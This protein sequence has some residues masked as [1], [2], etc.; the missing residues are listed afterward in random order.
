MATTLKRTREKLYVGIPEVYKMVKKRRKL[1][2][3]IEKA[4]EVAYIPPRTYRVVAK[5]CFKVLTTTPLTN[6]EV[7]TSL[8]DVEENR[9]P[10][11]VN[12][13]IVRVRCNVQ[14]HRS[15]DEDEFT[16]DDYSTNA[17]EI[18]TRMPID[19]NT[20]MEISL[21]FHAL[22]DKDDLWRPHLK[23]EDHRGGYKVEMDDEYDQVV[24]VKQTIMAYIPFSC[25]GEENWHTLI[26]SIEDDLCTYIANEAMYD[27][28]VA[29]SGGAID[30]EDWLKEEVF[31]EIPDGE[32]KHVYKMN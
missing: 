23:L 22:E 26:D 30:L 17:T 19:E 14:Y 28:K 31:C 12:C 1:S 2:G 3:K 9:W 8:G 25:A 4:K 16:L 27:E 20:R 7:R 29:R 21:R 5:D 15:Q 18:L 6:K 10:I 24:N 11:Q 32:T 13:A